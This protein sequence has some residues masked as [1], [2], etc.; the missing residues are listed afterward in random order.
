MTLYKIKIFVTKKIFIDTQLYC[1]KGGGAPLRL[2]RSFSMFFCLIDSPPSLHYRIHFWDNLENIL[3]VG[4]SILNKELTLPIFFI[5]VNIFMGM[6]DATSLIE[7]NQIVC[8]TIH[9]CKSDDSWYD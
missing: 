6:F 4:T 5:F 9:C 1:G 8:T 3:W 2:R 7:I